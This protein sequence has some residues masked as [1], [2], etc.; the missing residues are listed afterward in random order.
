V[1]CPELQPIDFVHTERFLGGRRLYEAA[2]E[3][4]LRDAPLSPDELN[5]YP[6][7]FP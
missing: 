6:H 5:P 4:G 7:P 1:I 2:H 3:L